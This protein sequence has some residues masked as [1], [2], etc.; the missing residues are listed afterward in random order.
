MNSCKPEVK[1]K[2]SPQRS[3]EDVDD[4]LQMQ[5]ARR[6]RRRYQPD[7]VKRPGTF[8]GHDSEYTS[9]LTELP[10]VPT[11][12]SSS[13]PAPTNGGIVTASACRSSNL[14][15]DLPLQISSCGLPRTSQ[16]SFNSLVNRNGL[17][18]VRSSDSEEDAQD[19]AEFERHIEPM[20][21]KLDS[22]I[23]DLIS[24]VD[25]ATDSDSSLSSIDDT[26]DSG[27]PT[28]KRQ[29][30]RCCSI[31]EAGQATPGQNRHIELRSAGMATFSMSKPM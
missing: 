18:A 19:E 23:L 14:S 5:V 30:S 31:A 24:E 1:T 7:N 20:A 2:H 27:D 25:R 10:G 21:G 16:L 11:L 17:K 12:P 29:D 26:S 3:Q 6:K 13:L 4:C 9:L 22:G 15:R 28:I 8:K